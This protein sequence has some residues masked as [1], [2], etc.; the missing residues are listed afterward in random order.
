[1]TQSVGDGVRTW[2]HVISL[3]D[4]LIVGVMTRRYPVGSWSQIIVAWKERNLRERSFIKTQLE[5]MGVMKTSSGQHIHSQQSQGL[6]PVLRGN[7]HMSEDR[8]QKRSS[9]RRRN[10]IQGAGKSTPTAE[11]CTVFVT[12]TP[13]LKSILHGNLVCVCVYIYVYV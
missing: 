1:M 11:A 9:L 6:R 10:M 3:L 13:N 5:L 2:I 12:L 7:A 8:R 4:T